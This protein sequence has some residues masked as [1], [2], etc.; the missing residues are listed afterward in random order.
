MKTR[1]LPLAVAA[2]LAA[3]L[4]ASAKSL[5][6]DFTVNG[7]PV[8]PLAN[9]TA[10]GSF[11]FDSSVIPA[12]GGLVSATGL[13]TGLAFTWDGLSY[14]QT[15]ANTGS[16]EFNSSGMLEGVNFGTSCTVGACNVSSSRDDWDISGRNPFG[17]VT[18][19]EFLYTVGNG[20][21]YSSYQTRLAAAPEIDPATTA[22]AITLLLGALAIVRARRRAAE[23]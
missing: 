10:S 4:A 15:T 12:G 3:S 17:N 18:S 6:Y 16:L 8:G 9:V 11:S 23:G 1:L 19:A 20:E 22:G 14:D 13:L 7:G 2:A 21:L 5:T